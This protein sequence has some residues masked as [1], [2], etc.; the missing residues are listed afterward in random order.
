MADDVELY[1]LWDDTEQADRLVDRYIEYIETN[2]W[3]AQEAYRGHY[4]WVKNG[5]IEVKVYDFP[6]QPAGVV[7]I[8]IIV[9]GMAMMVVRSFRIVKQHLKEK[10][11]NRANV[12]PGLDQELLD[13][14]AKE[15]VYYSPEQ[16]KQQAKGYQDK[17]K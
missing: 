1:R 10:R 3:T 7:G 12:R 6:I 15:V 2:H 13:E 8:M 16:L 4:E 9:P 5:Y 17:N 11:A 14:Q